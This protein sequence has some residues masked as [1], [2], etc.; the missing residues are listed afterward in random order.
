MDIT[1]HDG[2]ACDGEDDP[3]KACGTCG[4]LFGSSYARGVELV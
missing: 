4:I 1:P 2:D 3:V